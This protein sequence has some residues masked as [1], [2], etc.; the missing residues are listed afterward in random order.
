MSVKKSFPVIGM[1]CASCA[2]KVQ[3]TLSSQND[4]INVSVNLAGNS[5]AIEYKEGATP[6]TF[7]KAVQ[8]IG[9]DLDISEHLNAEEVESLRR[10]QLQQLKITTVSAFLLA[11]PVLI[12]GM[13]M[14][15]YETGKWVSLFLTAVIVFG[16]GNRF[17][18][19]AI[20][21]AR[22]F[23]ASMDTL[24]AISSG[25][26]FLFSAFNTYYHQVLGKYGMA[27]GVYFESAAMIVAFVLLGRWL[28]ERAKA[29]TSETIKQLF[30]LQPKTVWVRRN[31]IDQEVKTDDIEQN[32]IILIHPGERLPVDGIVLEGHSFVNES[33]ITGESVP[34]EKIRDA[35]VFAGT[36]NQTGSITIQSARIGKETVLAQIIK[37]VEEAQAS[38]PPVQNLVD[39]IAAVFVPIVIGI[40]LLTF[41][42][43][44]TLGGKGQLAR[45]LVCSVSVL[46]IAC[47][48]AL[49][50]ATPTAI[51]AG[52]GK[53][54]SK[55][56]LIR[57]AEAIQS[58][59]NL[60]LIVLDKTGTITTGKP[61][62]T[63]ILWV[64]DNEL[65]KETLAVI[66]S[67]SE[68]PLAEA[69]VKFLNI[70]GPRLTVDKFEALPGLGV[71]ASVQGNTY[72][73]GNDRLMREKQI[74]VS[75]EMSLKVEK[76]KAGGKTVIIFSNEKEVIGAIAF[77]DE[78]RESSAQAIAE[79]SQQYQVIML[80]GDNVTT[81]KA[82]AEQVGISIYKAEMS[83]ALK[84][85]F[86]NSQKASG[87]K[88][89]MT[90][91]G[92]ND[93]QALAVA[94]L[95]MAMGKGT[96]IAMST[97]D[98]TLMHNDLTSIMSAINLSKQIVRTI[99]QNLFW[100][101]IYNLIG[102]PVAAGILYP[103]TGFQLNPMIA[104]AAMA[105]SSV[106]V[107]LN[108][109]RLRRKTI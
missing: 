33:T 43:W 24:V 99:R 83:P 89:A 9:Y 93:T 57:R 104:A 65:L 90:G 62:V 22:H 82:I 72:F 44:L 4:I 38:R 17:F 47:P 100:A 68:H 108:S 29:R 8:A 105:G 18:V 77:A 20:K 23:T 21:Q 79:L 40:A 60:D 48:C 54:A 95:S 51:M 92:I 63:N 67:R 85:D 28:E 26:S 103:F 84:A 19:N 69:L 36:L 10:K 45:A 88:V 16:L 59:L 94:D 76:L 52:I 86:I 41:I 87:K 13:F 42:L 75:P 61:A 34:V 91:D 73:V 49:G 96:D 25:I 5:V 81:A 14:H 2:A 30:A 74:P 64:K 50:L 7:K 53:G 37:A 98:V 71:V 109:L 1:T 12:F 46:V 27:T 101:F 66:E 102:I 39:K 32:E 35:K 56:I 78:P 70:P 11:I 6:G 31:E 55:G 106:S 15:H 3:K 80:T 107:V 58:A 97:A